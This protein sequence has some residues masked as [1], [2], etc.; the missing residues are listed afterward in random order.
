MELMYTHVYSSC[1]WGKIKVRNLRLL[2]SPQY[3]NVK[4]KEAGIDLWS[5]LGGP[6]L[7]GLGPNGD[8]GE[9]RR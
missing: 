5:E 2:V 1:Y 3:L 7:F 8:N 4:T 9:C 6:A